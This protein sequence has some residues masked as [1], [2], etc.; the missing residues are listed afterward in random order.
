MRSKLDRCPFGVLPLCREPG[1]GW[2]GDI[3]PD[4]IAALV[5]LQRHQHRAHAGRA[6][7]KDMATKVA[8]A[9]R[10]AAGRS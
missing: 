1:C 10:R 4:T 6:A 2:R 7:A 8:A 5:A 9:R 3:E